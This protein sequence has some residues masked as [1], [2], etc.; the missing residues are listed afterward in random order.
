MAIRKNPNGVG[1]RQEPH[2]AIIVAMTR[3]GVIG[4]KNQI[5]WDLP[6]ERL[7]FRELTLGNTVIMGS[8]TFQSLQKPLSNRVNIVLTRSPKSFTGAIA[9]RSF[10]QSL[11][12]GWRIG[13]PIYVIGGVELYQMALPVADCL[14]ISWIKVT[15]KGDRCFPGFDQRKWLADEKREYEEFSYVRYRRRI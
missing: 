4:Y 6:E 15:F 7:L 9:C 2:L 8:H 1:T 13:K 11:I 5:P 10:F 14:H 12:L 3:D